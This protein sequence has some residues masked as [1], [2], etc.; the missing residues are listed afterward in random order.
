MADPIYFYPKLT[1]AGAAAAFNAANNGLEIAIDAVTFGAGIYDPD[2]TE[3]S[4]QVPL[5]TVEI[6][7]GSRVTPTQ[8]R[9]VTVWSDPDAEASITEIGYWSGSVLVFVWSRTVGGPIG[10]KTKGVDFVLFHDLSFAQVP[11]ESIT[12]QVNPDLNQALAALMSHETANN[13]H[14][15]YLLRRD[16]LDAHSL[17][18]ASSVGGSVN[19]INLTLPSETVVTQYKAGQQFVFVANGTNT[20]SVTVNVNGLGSKIVIKNGVSPLSAGD[21]ISGSVY[22]LFYDGAKMQ[23][24]AGVSGG[25]SVLVFEYQAEEGQTVF[26]ATYLPGNVFVYVNGRLLGRPDYVATNGTSLTILSPALVSGDH[27]L[28]FAFKSFS[29]PDAYRKEEV[30]DLLAQ[31]TVT[32]DRVSDATPVGRALMKSPNAPAPGFI[33]IN[34]DNTMSV[35][36]ASDTLAAIGGNNASNQ[37]TGTLDPARL[38]FM[39]VQQG[40]GA[41][42]ATNKVYMGW[43]GT[44]LKV[45]VDATDLGMVVFESFARN[46]SNLN[47]GTVHVD[48]LPMSTET[49]PGIVE[50]ATLD[51]VNAGVDDQRFL[52]PYKIRFGFS[53]SFGTTG[54]IKLPSWLGGYTRV[55]GVITAPGDTIITIPNLFTNACFS[56]QATNDI[57]SNTDQRAPKASPLLKGIQIRTPD[58][59]TA[60]I[61]Y[62]ADGH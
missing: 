2:G 10:I 9:L 41:G 47:A 12:V 38:P 15:Q 37:T 26:A 13:A 45:Q 17:I 53:F 34:A 22:T 4:L 59:S 35:L 42:Q 28:I 23:L 43:S 18:T 19:A 60:V 58:T 56:V 29:V 27:V 57:S 33:R 11:A 20:D 40:G 50:A 5:E 7:G 24:S 55:W 48:R 52:S 30:D 51:E 3:T 46:A 14:P 21:I 31:A 1:A 44:G 36:N 32:V 62:S 61:R 49:S 16:F 25:G 6:P 54:H 39:P 8:I